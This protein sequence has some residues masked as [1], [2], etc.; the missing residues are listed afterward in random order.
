MWKKVGKSC[1]RGCTVGLNRRSRKVVLRSMLSCLVDRILACCSANFTLIFLQLLLPPYVI[2]L[3]KFKLNPKYNRGMGSI[4]VTPA[5][6]KKWRPSALAIAAPSAHLRPET[7][8]PGS[9]HLGYL[10]TWKFCGVGTTIMPNEEKNLVE[11]LPSILQ[12]SSKRWRAVKRKTHFRLL[13][14]NPTV[15]PREQLFPT[16]FHMVRQIRVSAS[17]Q[18]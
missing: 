9:P 12:K 8:Y 14:F 10:E 17:C 2:M 18:N 15:H 4:S 1:S 11:I 3:T 13:L 16:F 5:T 6:G 7:F